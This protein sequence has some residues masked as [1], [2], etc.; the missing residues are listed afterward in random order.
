MSATSVT[1][2]VPLSGSLSAFKL[3]IGLIVL[4]VTESTSRELLLRTLG[5]VK[6]VFPHANP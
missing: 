4:E 6:D 1:T 5:C 2:S 3:S